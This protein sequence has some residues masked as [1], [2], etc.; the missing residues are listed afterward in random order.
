MVR[1]GVERP[2]ETASAVT[3]R[4]DPGRSTGTPATD[5]TGWPA[6]SGIVNCRVPV[7]VLCA[8]LILYAARP[9]SLGFYSD[10]W[11][12]LVQSLQDTAAFSPAR[13][14][15]IAGPGEPYVARPVGGLI[16]FAISSVAGSSPFAYQSV[17]ALLALVAALSLRAWL[18]S[19]SPRES[20]AHPLAA[21]LAAI[22]WLSLPW[23][24]VITA[25]PVCAMAAIPAQVFFTEAAR[26]MRPRETDKNRRL[27]FAAA[28]LLSSY[29]T[30]EAFYF[31]GILV[32]AYYCFR[33]G[34]RG[35]PRRYGF[36]LAAC[37]VQAVSVVFNRAIAHA[38]PLVSKTLAPQW[39]TLFRMSLRFLPGGLYRSAGALDRAWALAFGLVV[40]AAA[41]SAVVLLRSAEGKRLSGGLGILALGC[42]A[43]PVLCATYALAGYR[44]VFGAFESRT[45][46]GVSVE[47]ALI[48]Y[49]MLCVCLSAGRRVTA[50]VS[51]AA[52]LAFAVAGGMALHL[53]TLELAAVWREE[54]AVLRRVPVEQ[55]RA[56]PADSASEVLYIGPSYY[57]EIPIFGAYWELTGAVLSLPEMRDSR[58]RRRVRFFPATSFYDWSWD[59]ANLTRDPPGMWQAQAG[60]SALYVWNYDEGRLFRVERGF[61]WNPATASG[62]PGTPPLSVGGEPLATVATFLGI[63]KYTQGNWA[64]TYGIDG[65]SIATGS[66]RNPAYA[67][68]RL[69]GASTAVWG[70]PAWEV[71][72][73]EN[74]SGA[75]AVAS[76]TPLE[77]LLS[78]RGRL[79]SAWYSPSAFELDVNLHDGTT[80][81]VALY[82][83]DWDSAGARA[84]TIDVLDAATGTVLDARTISSFASG[85]YLV[86]NL[87]GHVKLRVT[88]TAGPSAVASGLF[89][90]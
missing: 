84:E 75:V 85:H 43:I 52:A 7:L 54:T 47:F 76:W 6:W 39:W 26:M 38:S 51:S 86:W 72:A 66:P 24:L 14:S 63:D 13:L 71:R 58:N 81:Q 88:R 64:G 45:L 89:F 67:T 46:A 53:H 69:A 36:V 20:G 18:R 44:I 78:A 25:W 62:G 59:G 79:G 2:P 74:F 50:V 28:L 27:W 19:F 9:F 90:R 30:Y 12:A 61:E 21:D 33:D 11:P 48:V 40:I 3:Y 68:T 15:R 17:C 23:S 73:L 16:V 29:L 70:A 35:A 60:K 41:C 83:V 42:A 8:W 82:C 31:L 57:G 55:I 34:R 1:C 32:A 4:E 10:D 5:R 37:A 77:R 87:R 49:G 22:V 56:L 80:H 65:F